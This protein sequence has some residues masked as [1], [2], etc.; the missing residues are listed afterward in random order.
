MHTKENMTIDE[1]R[2]HSRLTQR[3]H[4]GANR[5]GK[6]RLLG[7]MEAGRHHLDHNVGLAQERS[8]L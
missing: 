6:A 4:Q 5:K 2:K 7:E 8:Y 1:R 3:R